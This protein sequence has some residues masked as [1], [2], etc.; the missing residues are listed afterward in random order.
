M[1]AG[2]GTPLSGGPGFLLIPGDGPHPGM[3]GG[4]GEI[5]WAGTGFQR[6]NGARPGSTGTTGT[7]I[8]DGVPS[9]IGTGLWSL[10]TTGFTAGI[11]TGITQLSPVP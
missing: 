11:T 9:V 6:G 3:D 7:T 1:A 5:L 8:L 2:F 10:S 4:T